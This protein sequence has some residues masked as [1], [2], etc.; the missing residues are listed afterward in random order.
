MKTTSKKFRNLRPYLENVYENNFMC[1]ITKKNKN[2][3][4]KNIFGNQKTKN[5]LFLENIF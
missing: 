2:K 1:S 4:Q 3:K 5:S